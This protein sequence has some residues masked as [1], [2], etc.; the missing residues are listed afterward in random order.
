MS[1]SGTLLTTTLLALF[2]TGASATII[3]D[4][5]FDSWTA[6][7]SATGG[8]PPQYVGSLLGTGGNPGAA[9]S[10]QIIDTTLTRAANI[11]NNYSNSAAL[12]GQSFTL[13]FDALHVAGFLQGAGLA[14]QQGSN[15]WY[16]T[17]DEKIVITG[18]WTHFTMT[19]TF[20]SFS[21]DVISGSGSPNFS[22]GNVT[23]F[24]L[25]THLQG[26]T[27]DLAYYDNFK[28]TSSPLDAPPPAPEPSTLLL[29]VPV[30]ALALRR[31]RS[32][33]P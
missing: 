30:A 15:Y 13:E 12:A 16:F 4:G 32:S 6:V 22:S 33:R 21:F 3:T 20:N 2:A 5:S 23:K 28:L 25:Y 17:G 29:T 1:L 7:Y 24:G 10:S 27:P 19:G 31:R 18:A 8:S 11:K 14:V 26:S 9:W